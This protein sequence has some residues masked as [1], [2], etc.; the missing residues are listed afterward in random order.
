MT[1]IH[2]RIPSNKGKWHTQKIGFTDRH[3]DRS[4]LLNFDDMLTNYKNTN[5]WEIKVGYNLL[6]EFV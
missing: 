3:K 6:R 2:I 5:G 1:L 4:V